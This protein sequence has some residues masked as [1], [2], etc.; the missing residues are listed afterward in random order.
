MRFKVFKAFVMLALSLLLAASARAQD[1]L[2]LFYDAGSGSAATGRVSTVDGTYTNLQ[3]YDG[4]SFA[5]WTNIVGL[6]DGVVFFYD[7]TT[8]T[9]ATGHVDAG[10]NF[11]TVRTYGGFGYWTNVTW[12]GAQRL[13]F[14][15]S[16]TGNGATG[17]INPDGTF[18]TLQVYYAGFGY[19]T[20]VSGGPGGLV[21]FYDATTG[22]GASG[23]V[24]A[25][26]N[27][28]TLRLLD[29]FFPWT[30]VVEAGTTGILGGGGMYLFYDAATG[31]GATGMVRNVDGTFT[32]LNS[33]YGDFAYWTNVAGGVAV[34]FFYDSTSGN[35]ATGSVDFNGNFTTLQ[36]YGGFGS[37]THVIAIYQSSPPTP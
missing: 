18:T 34:Q 1:R 15:D 25:S 17:Q 7:N 27:V 20:H 16:T 23:R 3:A 2:L 12:V 10:G 8:L 22:N 14:Y 26:G 36:S 24:D 33:Y 9:G 21:L 31:N 29:G 11:T 5:Y 13:L 32:T 4:G 35:A 6:T 37:W 30:H 19:W 28:V